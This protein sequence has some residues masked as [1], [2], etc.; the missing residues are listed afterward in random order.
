MYHPTWGKTVPFNKTP[1]SVST[2]QLTSYGAADIM[3]FLDER[4][5]LTLGLR[6]QE[7]KSDMFTPGYKTRMTH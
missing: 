3:S 1:I 4:L 5:Q 7:V 6:Y 2:L